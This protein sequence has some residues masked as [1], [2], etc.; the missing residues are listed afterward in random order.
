MITETY[1]SF[2][3]QSECGH[4]VIGKFVSIPMMKGFTP[5]F[6][7]LEKCS[8]NLSSLS[9]AIHVNLLHPFVP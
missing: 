1:A 8:L 2:V 6:K 5:R 7:H 9:F 4:C 3:H